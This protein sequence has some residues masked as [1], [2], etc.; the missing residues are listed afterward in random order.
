[1]AGRSRW[2]RAAPKVLVCPLQAEHGRPRR[3]YGPI[4]RRGLEEFELLVTEQLAFERGLEDGG[5]VDRMKGPARRGDG[6]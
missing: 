5:A 4:P 2:E 6:S 3:R 1:M